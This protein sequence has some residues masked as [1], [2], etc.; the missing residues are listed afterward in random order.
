MAASTWSTDTVGT[1]E[2]FS[3]WHE[4]VCQAVL[5]VSTEAPCAGFRASISGHSLDGLR[6]ACFAADAH[7][8][9]RSRSHIARSVDEHYLVSFQIHG[10]SQISQA[11]EAFILE[12]GEIAILD[13]QRP[14]RVSFPTQVQRVLAVM[15]RTLLERRAP[16]LRKGTIRKIGSDSPYA[17]LAR[18][19]LLQLALREETPDTSEASLL[20]ENLCNLLALATARD[21]GSSERLADIQHQQVLAF[22]QQHL[23]DPNLAPAMVAAHCRISVRTVHLRF[24]RI[25]QSFGRWVVENR[26]EACRRDLRDPLQSSCGI[27]EIAYRW[28]FSDLSHFNRA[29]RNRFGMTPR[30]WRASAE[31]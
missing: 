10:R 3:Y 22:C 2:G 25:G 28:G 27:S 7:E 21:P 11:D 20:T 19:H 6:F 30:E 26:L 14:F 29:F 12:P 18:R 4:A 5:N 9:V 13:G 24:E 1:S 17:D 23:A 15:P 31:V 8:I 16:W